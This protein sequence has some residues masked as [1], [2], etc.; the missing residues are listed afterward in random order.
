MDS[1]SVAKWLNEEATDEEF[2]EVFGY[3]DLMRNGRKINCD[4]LTKET[5]SNIDINGITEWINTCLWEIIP[6]DTDIDES[7]WWKKN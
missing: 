3:L 6:K 5:M 2:A 1:Y 4:D 7:A